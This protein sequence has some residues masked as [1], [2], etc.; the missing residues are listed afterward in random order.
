M[1]DDKQT[2]SSPLLKKPKLGHKVN[3]VNPDPELVNKNPLELISCSSTQPTTTPCPDLGLDDSRHTD[4]NLG[5]S[6]DGDDKD[7]TGVQVA[8]NGV[9]G[10]S[11]NGDDRDKTGVEV[12][13][14]CIHV[15][16]NDGMADDALSSQR[17]QPSLP[18]EVLT[19]IV[20]HL[21]LQ[22]FG[23]DQ[24][25]LCMNLHDSY[26][27]A[28]KCLVAGRK[29]F[30]TELPLVN[31]RLFSIMAPALRYCLSVPPT[32]SPY[33]WNLTDKNVA[34]L[35]ST[36]FAPVVAHI[37]HI[38]IHWRNLY[39]TRDA[40]K[41]FNPSRWVAHL[42]RVCLG[43][44][45][46]ESLEMSDLI[47]TLE[48]DS[49][50]HYLAPNIE[51][52][53]FRDALPL[54]F[55]LTCSKLI[56]ALPKILNFADHDIWGKPGL[57]QLVEQYKLV[58][59]VGFPRLKHAFFMDGNAGISNEHY[60]NILLVPASK[61]SIPAE[62]QVFC[63]ASSP[64][65]PFSDSY[66][67]GSSSS[68]LPTTAS[69]DV[70]RLTSACPSLKS[71]TLVLWYSNLYIDI[72]FVRALVHVCQ[73]HPKLEHIDLISRRLRFDP[74]RFHNHTTSEAW[75]CNSVMPVLQLAV[76]LM[77]STVVATFHILANTR[78]LQRVIDEHWPPTNLQKCCNVRVQLMMLWEYTPDNT[79]DKAV[80]IHRARARIDA[81]MNEDKRQFPNV[82]KQHINS[83]F[84]R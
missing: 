40:A 3:P 71:L 55:D 39:S 28:S 53:L 19:L 36:L 4:N 12:A 73:H 34:I 1:A 47:L 41:P 64:P 77:P 60:A 9:N 2:S 38:H 27:L 33:L 31:S 66:N 11:G 29:W 82:Y 10:T 80:S 30:K 79:F 44:H 7:T 8:N 74:L 61:C 16:N 18:D 32:S 67:P 83:F 24:Q 21:E 26:C 14:S 62:Q 46:L 42:F 59:T 81:S 56:Q 23:P 69:S 45:R 52:G 75:F 35:A 63:T 84:G 65:L 22:L 6:G 43:A 50:N 13:S 25:Q 78:N 51:F 76:E 20:Q 17:S 68:D 70:C 58:D 54:Q 72:S 48:D 37:G 15:T 57:E 5:I 49:H